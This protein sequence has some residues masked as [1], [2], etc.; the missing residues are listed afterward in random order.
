MGGRGALNTSFGQNLDENGDRMFALFGLKQTWKVTDKW[1]VDSAF[2]RNQTLAN[3]QKYQF[4]ANYHDPEFWEKAADVCG[5]YL[6]PS[7]NAVVW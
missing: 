6:D 4:N 5:L 3:S 1:S 2:E 7:E